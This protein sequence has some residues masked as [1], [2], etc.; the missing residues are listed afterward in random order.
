VFDPVC[1]FL[2]CLL[3]GLHA[4]AQFTIAKMVNITVQHVRIKSINEK[5]RQLRS[6]MLDEEVELVE[7]SGGEVKL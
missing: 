1:G 3:S 5:P 4:S 2:C 6:K 7:L